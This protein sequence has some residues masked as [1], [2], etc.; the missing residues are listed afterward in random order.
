[1]NHSSNNTTHEESGLE[2]RSLGGADTYYESMPVEEVL[3]LMDAAQTIAISG[4]VNPDGDALGSALALR[5]LLEA[6]GKKVDILLGQESPALELYAFLP[7]YTFVHASDYSEI[8]DLF[9]V[10]DASTSKRLSAAE[11]F[12]QTAGDT[13]VI[14]HH[15]NYEGFA[16]HYFGDSTAPAAASLIWRIIKASGI[17]PT[18]N[19]ATYCYVGIMT[20]TG[21][22]AFTNTDR[23][24][25][26]DATEMVD[27]GVDPAELSQLVYQSKSVPAMRLEALIIDRIKF[28][29][30]NCVVYS[31]LLPDDLA[32]LGLSRD[33]T[34]TIPTLLRCIKDVEVAVLFR[35]EEEEGVRVNLRSRS[36]YNVGTFACELGGGGHA[37]AAGFTLAMPLGEA[38]P[39]VLDALL[40]DLA[41]G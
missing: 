25:F 32:S 18:R 17:E 36:A 22:F 16:Q 19:M 23:S 33:D 30:N 41:C 26:I 14:D 3:A 4:H 40:K 20:D 7:D 34:E 1:M 9:I 29:C 37:G 10:V 24:A 39:Y 31:Y 13:L 12:L 27:L 21:R 8:P 6:M 11:C 2:S 35:D 5:D 15:A 28:A 38:I